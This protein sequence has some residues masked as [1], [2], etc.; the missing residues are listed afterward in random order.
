MFDA[1]AGDSFYEFPSFK[2]AL[3]SIL[4]A[5]VLSSVIA[6]TYHFTDRKTAFSRNFYQSLVLS[7]IVSCMVIMAVG[8]NIAA[9]FGIIGAIAII[10]FRMRIENPRNIIFIFASLSVGIGAGVYGYSI[11]L[12]GTIAFCTVSLILFYS[13]FG[14]KSLSREFRLGFTLLA[15]ANKSISEQFLIESTQDLRLLTVSSGKRG[16]RF[17]YFITLKKHID[18]DW[19]YQELKKMEGI[20]NIRLDRSDNLDKL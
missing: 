7:S 8:N 6:F 3:F 17:E 2:V 1:L 18:K 16:D 20:V 19:F 13:P 4:L 14:G 15:E 9:G 12:A 5:F 10:R 11:A